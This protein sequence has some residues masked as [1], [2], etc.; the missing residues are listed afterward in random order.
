MKL[1][2]SSVLKTVSIFCYHFPNFFFAENV[3]NSK[4]CSIQDAQQIFL[5]AFITYNLCL[6]R[7]SLAVSTERL[8]T[9]KIMPRNLNEIV[10]S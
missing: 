8:G 5:L 3:T 2:T 10:H 9:L 4:K 6:N 7:C 1:I